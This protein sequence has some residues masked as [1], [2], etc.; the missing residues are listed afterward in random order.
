LSSAAWWRLLTGRWPLTNLRSPRELFSPGSTIGIWW[1]S[2]A[3]LA[4]GVDPSAGASFRP[5][6]VLITVDTFRPDHL[7]YYGYHRQTSPQLDAISAEGV[8][9]KQAFSSSA[10]TTPGLIS[11]LTSLY[12]PT[13]EVDI[14][15]RRL[16]PRATTLPD[17]LVAE[18]YRAPDIFFLTEIPNFSNLGLEAYDRREELIDRGDEV[19]FHWLEEEVVAGEPFFLYYHYRDLHLPYKPGEP[20]E[21]LYLPEAFDAP[22]GILSALKRFLAAEKMAVVKKSVMITRGLMDFDARDRPWVDALYDAQ[23]RR[24]D[25]EFFGRLRRTLAREGLDENTLVII[26]AD[27]GEELLDRDLIGHVSTFKE[28][29]LYD[30]LTRIPL[31]FWFPGVLPAGR[32][33]EEP[34]QCIDVTPTILDLLDLP[35]AQGMQGQSLLPLIEERDGWTQKPLFFETSGAG[36][37]ADEAQYRQRFRAVRT[38]R[39]KL[40]HSGPGEAYALYDLDDD[41][42]ELEEVGEEY[43]QVVDSLRVLLN[44]WVLFSQRR[45]YREREDAPEESRSPTVDRSGEKLKI[46]FPQ[47]GDTLSYQGADHT[48]RLQWDGPDAETYVIEYEVGEGAYHL[49][50]V[51]TESRS[52]PG[53]GPFQASMWNSLV[54]YNPWKFRVYLPD[55]PQE[56]S[57]WV[58]FHLASSEAEEEGITLLGVALMARQAVGSGIDHAGNLIWGLGRGVVDIYLWV[59][60]VPAADLSAYALLLVIAGAIFWPY[61]QRWG[62]ARCRTWG[63]ALL[64]IAFVYST[65]SVMPEVWKVLEAYTR[66]SI[67]Y[68]GILA[69]GLTAAV[70]AIGVWRRIQR[71]R[72]SPYVALALIM[73]IYAY[74]LNRYAVFPSERLHLVEYGFMGVV[75]FRALRIDFSDRFAYIASF[76][77]TVLIGLGDECI[78]WVLPQRFF[79]LKDV[80]LNALSGGLG[81]LILRFVVQPAEEG[82]GEATERRPEERVERDGNHIFPE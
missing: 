12:A 48:I 54:L 22:L 64:Y 82:V 28:G 6:I 31:I 7:S 52:A 42:G 80:Q 57:D 77:A 66:G 73:P 19:L 35:L 78:Q 11:I 75:L 72:W 34:V 4:L 38:E 45:A 59:G 36:Y 9:F 47:D 50:G 60:S 79:E 5:N 37:T 68:L 26:S 8:F 76:V 15:G 29:R 53:Y 14:R 63:V 24:L 33:I 67:R 3:L 17:L 40:I 43:P 65:I 56:K 46:L 16:D 32:V 41:P 2:V 13:H 30:E 49:E 81:L 69:V 23:I 27:H 39:W 62:V 21:S 55:N 1:L 18:G 44:E 25:E 71:R 61:V 58:T 70:I 20:Y 51:T 74:L 10:W